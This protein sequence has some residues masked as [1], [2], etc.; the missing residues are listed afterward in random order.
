MTTLN[1]IQKKR[2]LANS[3]E[4]LFNLSAEMLKSPKNVFSA[5]ILEPYLDVKIEN[6]ESVLHQ[7][8]H[9]LTCF[10]SRFDDNLYYSDY[11]SVVTYFY[12]DNNVYGKE[13]EKEKDGLVSLFELEKTI[14]Q[15]G[16]NVID[17]LITEGTFAYFENIVMRVCINWIPEQGAGK[18]WNKLALQ[19]AK[20]CSE[21]HDAT[22]Q[23]KGVPEKKYKVHKSVLKKQSKVFHAMLSNN[24]MVEAQT[25]NIIIEVSDSAQRV[26]AFEA[27][28]AILYDPTVSYFHRSVVKKALERIEFGKNCTDVGEEEE[29]EKEEKEEMLVYPDAYY[30]KEDNTIAKARLAEANDEEFSFVLLELLHQY[31]MQYHLKQVERQLVGTISETNIVKYYEIANRFELQYLLHAC[32]LFSVAMVQKHLSAFRKQDKDV[33]TSADSAFHET[34]CATVK[35]I[36]LESIKEKEDGE[37]KVEGENKELKDAL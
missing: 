5:S 25:G 34:F 35:Q 32:G 37:K 20:D 10:F 18:K 17:V 6:V 1:L 33:T 2:K 26:A 24:L 9:R 4:V 16:C 21:P 11:A 13:S 36:A 27:F 12:G 3:K 31:S 30:K 28:I 14:T 23:I 29:A 19:Y 22:L 8:C 15:C 7:K